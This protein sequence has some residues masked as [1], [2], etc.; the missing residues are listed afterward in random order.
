ML[1]YTDSM[2]RHT[3]KNT[4]HSCIGRKKNDLKVHLYFF[5]SVSLWFPHSSWQIATDISCTVY[6]CETG[7]KKKCREE[8]LTDFLPRGETKRK[9]VTV[10]A[11]LRCNC[12]NL[13]LPNTCS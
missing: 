3:H 4:R 8:M 2:A 9:K 12:S 11:V 10:K 1:S 13:K 6:T 7:G 5:S